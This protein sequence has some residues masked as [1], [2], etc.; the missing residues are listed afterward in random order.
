VDRVAREEEVSVVVRR[1]R[2]RGGHGRGIEELELYQK[3]VEKGVTAGPP[4][5]LMIVAID[6][7]CTTFAKKRAQILS[8]TRDHLRD[9]IVVACPD[10]HVERWYLGDPDS[11]YEAVGHRPTV[12]KRKC[13]RDHYKDLLARAVRAG[14]HPATLGGIEFAREI[15][16][17]MNWYRAGRSDASLK[18][19]LDDLRGSLRRARP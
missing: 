5:D 7:N 9:R 12:G 10:P 17:H 6:G 16:Q 1:R 11:F 15:V 18:A 14:D 2:A 13:A 8:A 19:F 4:P 3:L